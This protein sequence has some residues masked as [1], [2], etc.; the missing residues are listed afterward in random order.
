MGYPVFP[1]GN[2]HLVYILPK[3]KAKQSVMAVHFGGIGVNVDAWGE[4]ADLRDMGNAFSFISL[5]RQETFYKAV[6]W[7]C[8][9]SLCFSPVLFDVDGRR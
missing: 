2:L 8:N 3:G 1:L 9:L 4:R 6:S 7:L 5:L